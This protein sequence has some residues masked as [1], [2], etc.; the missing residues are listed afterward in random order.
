MKQ[1]YTRLKL[2]CYSANIS[3][4]IVGNLPPV[5]FLTFRSLYG[6]SYSLLGLLV[7]INFVTQLAVDLVF[8]FFSHKFNISKTVKLMP[9]IT[10]VGFLLYALSPVL[11]SEN[12]YIG[13]ALGTVIFSVSSGL[14]EVLISPVI[15]AIPADDPDREMSKLH[16]V[17]AWGSVF[18]IIVSTL[19]L[20]FFGSE[21]WQI[22]AL[23]FT[24]VP[25]SS[26][27]LYLGSEIPKMETPEKASGALSLLK[28]KGVWLCV[29]AI[30]LGGAAECTMAQWCSGYIEKALGIPKVWGDIF[31]VA[32]FSVALGTG[33]T[34]YAKKGKNIEKVLLWGAVGA[35]IC[36][37]TAAISNIA[38]IGLIACAFTGFC[39]SMLWPGNLVVAS[40]RFPKG[41]VFI[42]ALM[43]AGGDLGASVG[44]QLIGIITD[45]V[46]AD[47]RTAELAI[48]L[49]ASAEQLGM[50]LGMLVGMLFPLAAI[51]VFVKFL[52]Q[53][54][55]SNLE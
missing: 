46:A 15:A 42:Y 7:L 34:L 41:G 4:S 32:L 28:N 53:K 29:L 40:E 45:T 38:V 8:S 31:G 47:P 11:F 25:V 26:L 5:L 23:I 54:K 22:L 6:I 48:S 50:K 18:V 20:L 44:P 27:I 39:V 3:M 33:R 14:S 51:F 13:L 17:Y 43:A 2:A 10:V 19:F 9:I 24:V 36:Y 16:S 1:S 21:N 52:K 12:V 37:F 49:G 35:A 55:K 30:F